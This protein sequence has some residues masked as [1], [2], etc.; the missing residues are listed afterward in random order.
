MSM[1]ALVALAAAT[2]NGNHGA[3][4]D[5][6]NEVQADKTSFQAFNVEASKLATST[7]PACVWSTKGSLPVFEK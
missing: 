4:A 2:R 5:D 7:G 6:F 1:S 3:A